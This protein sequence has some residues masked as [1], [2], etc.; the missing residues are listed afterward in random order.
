MK[1]TIYLTALLLCMGMFMPATGMAQ[2]EPEESLHSIGFGAYYQKTVGDIK[3]NDDFDEDAISWVVSYQYALSEYLT[4][5]ADLEFTP[6]FGGSDEV[7]YLPQAYLLF[8][9]WI[10]GGAGIGMGY[11]DSEW[12]DRP[13]YAFRAGLDLPLGDRLHVDVNANYRFISSSAFDEVD[14][15]DADS[16]TFG[17]A[18]RIDL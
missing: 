2:G 16:I 11:L 14:E 5:E 15:D 7:F 18:L 13:V 1:L 9:T 6:D 3:D 10:Y 17:A 12:S 8:G 4:L